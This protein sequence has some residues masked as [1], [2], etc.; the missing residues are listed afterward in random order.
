[1]IGLLIVVNSLIMAVEFEFQGP[2]FN[3]A[4]RMSMH[5]RQV[6]SWGTS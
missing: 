5:I 2:V 3:D 1:M 4:P 6:M